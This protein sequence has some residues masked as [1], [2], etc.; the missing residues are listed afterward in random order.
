MLF[1]E[2][3]FHPQLPPVHWES[4]Q[5]PLMMENGNVTFQIAG[6]PHQWLGKLL[7]S[8]N[9]YLY[10][11]K[12]FQWIG[13]AC[14][15]PILCSHHWAW[16]VARSSCCHWVPNWWIQSWNWGHLYSLWRQTSTWIPLVRFHKSLQVAN[17][18]RISWNILCFLPCVMAIT[19]L[20]SS[21]N[22]VILASFSNFS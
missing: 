1:I 4:T 10:F 6:I 11:S 17:F 22:A 5:L 21:N 15:Q 18:L 8:K 12:S 20:A 13:I 9:G 7:I 3:K 2:C 16:L 19:F 14:G